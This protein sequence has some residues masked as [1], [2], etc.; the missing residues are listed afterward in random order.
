ML[1]CFVNVF[2][3]DAVIDETTHTI[4]AAQILLISFGVRRLAPF[5]AI[6]FIRS[7]LQP[8]AV[9]NL[10]RDCVLHVDDVGGVSVD[11][12][13]PEQLGRTTVT[14]LSRTSTAI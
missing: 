10:L 12:I 4:A 11:A 14:Q 6:L 8:Q 13:A 7:Q 5:Q 3:G 1:D 9:A 2:A